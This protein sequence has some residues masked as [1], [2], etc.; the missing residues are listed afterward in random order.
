MTRKA[1]GLEARELSYNVNLAMSFY[2]SEPQFTH[3][4]NWR[5]A[6]NSLQGFLYLDIVEFFQLFKTADFFE[7]LRYDS[8]LCLPP[9]TLVP[10][11]R[12]VI[13]GVTAPSTSQNTPLGLIFP[14]HPLPSAL[15]PSCCGRCVLGPF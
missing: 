2:F 12:L 8:L 9:L 10:S 11:Q 7:K 13:L 15:S 6:R 14:W 5:Y 4:R 1:L 3:L